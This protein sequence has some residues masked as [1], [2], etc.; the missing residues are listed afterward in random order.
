M[1]ERVEQAFHEFVVARSVALQ[2]SA[3]LLT[4]DRGEAEDAVQATLVRVY[5]AWP[6]IV[7]HGAMEAYARKVLLREVLSWRRKRR[8]RVLLTGTTPER[9][10]VDNMAAVDERDRL[11]RALLLLP[12]RQRAVVVLRYYDDQTEAQTAELLGITPG[13]VKTHASR[14]LA[15]LRDALSIDQRETRRS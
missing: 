15:R 12:A 10:G 14:G 7:H 13:A 1:D 4:G 2:R 6:R 9:G 8:V 5:L 11:Q 3:F